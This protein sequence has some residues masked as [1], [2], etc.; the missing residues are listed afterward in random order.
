MLGRPRLLRDVREELAILIAGELARAA[1]RAA[2]RERLE[3]GK[4]AEERMDSGSV[5]DA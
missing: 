4:W 2:D 1:A 3:D 5:W